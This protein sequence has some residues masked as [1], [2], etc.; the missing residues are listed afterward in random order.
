M[1]DLSDL[2]EAS[3]LVKELRLKGKSQAQ[4]AE[5]LRKIVDKL[6]PYIRQISEPVTLKWGMAVDGDEY[7]PIIPASEFSVDELSAKEGIV[8]WSPSTR[9]PFSTSPRG[10]QLWILSSGRFLYL[11]SRY[12]SDKGIGWAAESWVGEPIESSDPSQLSLPLDVNEICDN[13]VTAI[14]SISR[15]RGRVN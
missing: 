15:L 6:Q 7:T 11:K 2:R 12:K 13:L 3:E 1:N 8:I 9:A 4:V 5:L 10:D 14:N